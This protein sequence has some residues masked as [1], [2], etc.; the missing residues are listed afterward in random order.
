[1]LVWLVLLQLLFCCGHSDVNIDGHATSSSGFFWGAFKSFLE[2]SL[3]L[4]MVSSSIVALGNK[5][6]REGSLLAELL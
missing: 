5:E 4:V 2:K 1:M 6:E 3:R